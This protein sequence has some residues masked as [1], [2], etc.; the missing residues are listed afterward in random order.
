MQAALREAHGQQRHGPGKTAA[1]SVKLWHQGK[2]AVHL[3]TTDEPFECIHVADRGVWLCIAYRLHRC[4][5]AMLW[6]PCAL[7]IS[8]L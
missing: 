6:K 5:T 1:A 4:M 3:S 8:S 7:L 2:L